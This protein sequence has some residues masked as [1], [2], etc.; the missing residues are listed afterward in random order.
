VLII[1][2]WSI[3]DI[4]QCAAVDSAR[5]SPIKTRLRHE[6]TPDLLFFVFFVPSW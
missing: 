5:Q 4:V 2:W 1:F 6:H 3:A